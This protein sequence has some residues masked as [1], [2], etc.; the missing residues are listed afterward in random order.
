[1]ILRPIACA[2]VCHWQG[3]WGGDPEE[4]ETLSGS[5]G[6]KGHQE[7]QRHEKLIAV[8]LAPVHRDTS[9]QVQ[10]TASAAPEAH[11]FHPKMGRLPVISGK[12]KKG[13][14]FKPYANA[15]DMCASAHSQF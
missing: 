1:M 7:P 14:C 2:K 9:S 13:K 3:R 4:L 12:G 15:K 11:L 8:Q 5:V 6:V 10:V